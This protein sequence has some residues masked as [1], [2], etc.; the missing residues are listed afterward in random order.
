M[1][2]IP[3]NVRNIYRCEHHGYRGWMVRVKRGAARHVEYFSDGGTGR[4]ASFNRAM[5]YRDWLLKQVPA[6]NKLK[7]RY[8]RNT[9]GEIGVARCVERTRAGTRFVRY[10]ATWPTASDGKVKRSFSASKYGMLR[11]RR[12]AIQARRRGVEEMLRQ[13]AKM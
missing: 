3:R 6:F 7:R 9:T 2:G 13:R 8:E 4:Q 12:L 5:A 1:R 10:A 11:A